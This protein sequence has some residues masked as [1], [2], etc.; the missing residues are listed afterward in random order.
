MIATSISREGFSAIETTAPELDL[1]AHS[2]DA[3]LAARIVRGSIPARHEANM[4]HE[5]LD[6]LSLLLLGGG[7]SHHDPMDQRAR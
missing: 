3:R 4:A 6:P 7:R 2:W 5:R 1:A